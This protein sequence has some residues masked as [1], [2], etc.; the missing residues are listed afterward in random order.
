MA[1]MCG[2]GSI[3]W[4]LTSPDYVQI[5]DNLVSGTLT[6]NLVKAT[7][8][9]GLCVTFHY[10]MDIIN[11]TLSVSILYLN[12]RERPVWAT[13]YNGT[14]AH[15]WS[16]VWMHIQ[17]ATAFQLVF[18]AV[19]CNNLHSRIAIKAVTSSPYT[20]RASCGS[21]SPGD[22]NHVS[23][24]EGCST[25]TTTTVPTE[26]TTMSSS[27]LPTTSPL[28][29]PPNATAGKSGTTGGVT[30]WKGLSEGEE[31]GQDTNVAAIVGPVVAGV[32][33]IALVFVAVL[34]WKKHKPTGGNADGADLQAVTLD[35]VCDNEMNE[36]SREEET[37]DY[38]N[39]YS[40]PGELS[41]ARQYS[42]LQFT[43]PDTG[44]E[45]ARATYCNMRQGDSSAY[46]NVTADFGDSEQRN[47]Y[48]E[49]KRESG[50]STDA[51]HAY[52]SLNY[53]S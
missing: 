13:T 24:Y 40:I 39:P 3:S 30:E 44:A 42:A 37:N 23:L 25:I 6:T 15:S 27:S 29:F 7:T 49:L 10:S 20:Y 11:D 43:Q 22:R 48:E 14:P 50:T 34:F 12:V 32:V 51:S 46:C 26:S 21:R 4:Q 1:D 9:G 41:P 52:Q 38:L 8:G 53:S 19:R 16:Q 31:K 2:W 5:Q 18:R 17:S 33:V 45:A 47:T 35:S 28:P 36:Q